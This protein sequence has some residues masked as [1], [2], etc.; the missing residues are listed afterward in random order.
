MGSLFVPFG[1]KANFFSNLF[2]NDVLASANFVVQDSTE[3]NSQTI[4]LLKANVSS[5]IIIQDK[6]D[7]N[8]KNNTD[9][10]DKNK[11]INIVSDSA[12]LPPTGPSGVSDGTDNGDISSD[13][14]SVYVVRK[15][16]SIAQIAGMFGVTSNTVLWANDMKKGDKLVPDDVLIILPVTGVQVTVAKGQTL[17]SLAT[18]YKVDVSDI[19]GFNGIASDAKLAIGDELIIPDGELK[20]EGSTV[21]PLKTN[22]G[23]YT[24]AP[25]I[26]ASGY[27]INPVPGYKNRSQGLHDGGAIDLAA[28]RGTP[29]VA[30]ASGTVI[31]AREAYNGGYGYMVMINHP[32]GTQ[33]LYGHMSQILTHVGEKISQGETIGLVGS[34]GHSTGPHLH[35]LVKGAKNPGGTTPMSWAS[36]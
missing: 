14:I 27:F 32:N 36:R 16:D 6:K 30:S 25:I 22:G 24:K 3:T 9:T 15:G 8:N 10:I 12:L 13:Q 7:K 1:V 18:L 2:G 31:F 28:S 35:F 4:E 17:K 23:G 21:S 33:T 29:I 11:D 26:Y 19:A 5:A 34:T 20:D